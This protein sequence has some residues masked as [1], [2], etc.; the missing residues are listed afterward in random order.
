MAFEAANRLAPEKIKKYIQ[1]HEHKIKKSQQ[2]NDEIKA[3]KKKWPLDF[4]TSEERETSQK[5][6]DALVPHIATRRVC[7][8]KQIRHTISFEDR[9]LQTMAEVL[10]EEIESQIKKFPEHVKYW[11]RDEARR[12][13]DKILPLPRERGVAG[14]EEY[15][16]AKTMGRGD[17]RVEEGFLRKP[18]GVLPKPMIRD[19]PLSGVQEKEA[20]ELLDV[21]PS[22][23]EED[24]WATWV[25][26][27]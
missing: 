11:I 7:L 9:I 12:K 20:W 13:A 27:D 21:H 8:Q 23:R 19:I 26:V 16:K 5:F 17:R 14:G 18:T 3:L 15:L 6:I 25:V 10:T 1:R 22:S 24:D 2:K 4:L